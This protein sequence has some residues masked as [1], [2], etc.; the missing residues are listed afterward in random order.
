MSVAYSIRP[1][2]VIANAPAAGLIQAAL[3]AFPDLA[4]VG[5]VGFSYLEVVR[6]SAHEA[7]HSNAFP[8]H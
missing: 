1:S 2:K 6:N 7:R 8:C 5:F 3:A 4:I